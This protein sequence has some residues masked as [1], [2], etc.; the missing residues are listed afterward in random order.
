MMGGLCINLT[1]NDRLT[2]VSSQ[3][4]HTSHLLK[5]SVEPTVDENLGQYILVGSTGGDSITHLL[6]Y[7]N[8]NFKAYKPHNPIIGGVLSLS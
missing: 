5:M 1:E 3:K 4:S 2:N 6:W 8:F 7:I